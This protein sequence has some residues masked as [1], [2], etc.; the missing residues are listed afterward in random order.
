MREEWDNQ[1]VICDGLE[2]YLYERIIDAYKM[3]MSVIEIS[4]IIGRRAD[5][6]HDLLR[7][8]GRIKAIERRGSR[9]K[10][11]LNP[12]LAKEFG[13]ISYSFARW[14][15]GW[16]FDTGSAAHAIRLPHDV[17]D[18]DQYVAALRRDFPH[19][20]CKLHDMPPSQLAPLFTEDEHPSVEINW[21]EERNCYL[22]RVVEYPEIEE[23]GRTLTRA[24]KRMAD[25]YR[26]KQIDEAI[27]LYENVLETNGKVSAPCFC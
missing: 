18:P 13:A 24:F 16:K 27:T 23:N 25:S 17:T 6:V 19:Y 8:A 11:S 22:A 9:S 14:C 1:M 26:I 5:H 10:F 3:G 4:R 20:F 12:M 7:K 21:D 2:D 15:A